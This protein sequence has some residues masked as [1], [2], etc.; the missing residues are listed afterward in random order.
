MMT[1][2]FPIPII[3][4][5]QYDAFRRD[6]GPDLADTYD[7]WFEFVR[8][9]RSERLRQGETLVD[10]EVDYDEFTRFCAATGTKPT[11][12]TLLDFAIEKSPL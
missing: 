4:K 7:E 5:H 6:V 12:K 9:H 2:V 8:K 1:M 3:P 10:V 11:A